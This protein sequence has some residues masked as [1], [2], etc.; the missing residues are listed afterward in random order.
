MGTNDLQR[1]SSRWSMWAQG[2][3][4]EHPGG[5]R[6]ADPAAKGPQRGAKGSHRMT[7]TSQRW[8][9]E[10]QN[11]SKMSLAMVKIQ[12]VKMSKNHWFF[13]SKWLGGQPRTCQNWLQRTRSG[14]MAGPVAG[15]RAQ[16]AGQ[17]AGQGRSGGRSGPKAGSLPVARA[18]S[19]RSGGRSGPVKGPGQSGTR[20]S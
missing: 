7:K 6:E 18:R 9:K 16:M 12:N 11:G 3:L 15:Q 8:A 17:M 10:G 1:G 19:G 20:K 14:Q 4:L 2:G 13:H 5:P